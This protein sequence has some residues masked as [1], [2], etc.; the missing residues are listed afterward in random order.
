MSSPDSIRWLK[1]PYPEDHLRLV[2][3]T[4]STMVWSLSPDGVLDFVNQRWIAYTGLSIEE[5]LERPNGIVHP[6][7]LPRVMERWIRDRAAARPHED[8]IRLRRADGEY[9]WFLVRTVP[10]LDAEGNIV[11]WYG[12]STDIED[13][14][15]AAVALRES[16][17]Q[18]R[19]LSRR[20]V[21]L[22]ESERRELCRELHDQVGQNLTALKINI[23]I[24]R[25]PLAAQGD[26]QVV[27]RIDDSA[28]LLESTM[29]AI[30]S[31]LY[32]LRPP[33]LDDLGLAAALDWH[34]RLFCG[35]TGIAVTVRSGEPAAVRLTPRVE[36]ALFRIAQEA[37]NNI[38][39]HARA[40]SAEIWLDH[41]DGECVMRVRDDGV[42]FDEVAD[43]PDCP[44]PGLGMAMMRERS[45]SIGGRFE[46]RVLPGR[47]SELEVRIPY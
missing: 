3:D 47:G 42:G 8:E 22:Q 12:T 31:L 4:I 29:N 36:I 7:D 20:L 28:A 15:R 27:A 5:A 25:P 13:R 23:A 17:V 30:R 19:A 9:R 32:E 33:M 37:L 39:K 14:K 40:R 46:A 34:A 16:E 1:P 35:R 43:A 11:K 6:D 21:D 38:A 24:L 41:A 26:E 2:I 45:Q 10:L 44:R 18:L